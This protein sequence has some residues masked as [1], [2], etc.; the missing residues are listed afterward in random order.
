MIAKEA[1]HTYNCR[2][3]D[4]E[5]ARKLQNNLYLTAKKG[6]RK[7]YALYGNIYRRRSG[8]KRVMILKPDGKKRPL[9]LPTIRDKAVQMATKLIIAPLFEADFKD[10]GGTL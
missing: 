7:F 4:K 5:K 3:K 10:R 8:V 9:G 2:N 6:S 1:M